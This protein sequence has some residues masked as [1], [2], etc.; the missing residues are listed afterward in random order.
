MCGPKPCNLE[1]QPDAETLDQQTVLS[2]YKETE[3]QRL[4]PAERLAR[5]WAL[6]A[7]LVNPQD[8]HDSK[9]FPAP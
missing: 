4:S 2:P 9:L 8:V 1:G 6:R 5:A 7:R 3:W